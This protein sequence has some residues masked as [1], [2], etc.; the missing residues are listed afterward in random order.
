MKKTPL[1]LALMLAVVLSACSTG[2]PK[3]PAAT[4][5]APSPA[6]T[7]QAGTTQAGVN[8]DT[9]TAAAGIF[10]TPNPTQA[11]ALSLFPPASESDW[12]MGRADAAVTF[13]E[14]SDFQ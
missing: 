9:C 4:A 8:G 10:P 2:T 11:A 13:I 3:A 5:S 1:F 14:Y 7:T 6:G 12:S